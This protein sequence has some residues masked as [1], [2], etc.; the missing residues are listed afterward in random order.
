MSPCTLQELQGSIQHPAV[1]QLKAIMAVPHVL[2]S[3]RVRPEATPLGRAKIG[4][5]VILSEVGH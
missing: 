1:V 5:A 3:S 4:L 2:D